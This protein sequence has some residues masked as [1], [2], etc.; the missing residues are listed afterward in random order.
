MA[1]ATFTV[2]T[3]ADVVNATD[4]KLSLREAVAQANATIAADTIV[5][6]AGL[7]GKTL[8][9][10]AGELTITQDLTIDGDR[11]DD[12]LEV[13]LSGGNRQRLAEILGD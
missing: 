1:M 4:G 8:V 9:L 11:D 12:G 5:F 6:A 13:T 2:T 7:E 3:A 10:T